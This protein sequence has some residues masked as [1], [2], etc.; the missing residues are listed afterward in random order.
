MVSVY[1]DI[2]KFR[3]LRKKLLETT[4]H[5]GKLFDG[6]ITIDGTDYFL[7]LLL[8]KPTE[9]CMKQAWAAVHQN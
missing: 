4:G 1:I 7:R 2:E 8:E 6:K 9:I 3:Q 5:S